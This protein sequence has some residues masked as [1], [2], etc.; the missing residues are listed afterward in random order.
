MTPLF[1]WVALS[2]AA[3]PKPPPDRWIG[4]DKLKH[5]FTSFVA[6]SLAASA[7][8]SAGLDVGTSVWVGAGAGAAVGVWK[9]IRDQGQRDN[10][11]SA[12]DLVW[13]LAGVGA[14]VA[15]LSRVR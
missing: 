14:G 4:E 15:V 3:P 9:E 11:A 8:R 12:K 6:T 5:F 7:T 10:R 2:A 13:D 1:L